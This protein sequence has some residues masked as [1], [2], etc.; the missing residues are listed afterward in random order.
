[1]SSTRSWRSLPIP[2][3][4][5]FVAGGRITGTLAQ[6]LYLHLQMIR[7]DVRLLPL[8]GSWPHHLLDLREGDVFV[9]FDVRRYENTTMMMAQMCVERGAEVVLFTDQWRS[10]IRKVA[11]ITF[12]GRIAVP[13]AWDSMASLLLLIE[14]TIAALQETL[15]DSVKERTDALETAFDRTRLFRK[16][17]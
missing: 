4:S 3:G 7:P 16:F 14:C 2:A 13:S 17:G 15:W 5:V 6:Y 10:P 1:M 8:G 9:A 12:A 11:R